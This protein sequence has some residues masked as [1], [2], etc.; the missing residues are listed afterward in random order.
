MSADRKERKLFVLNEFRGLDT[1]NKQLKVDK[2]RASF[3]YNFYSNSKTLKTR[4]A[5]VMKQD[6]PFF[7]ESGD[8]VIGWYY[9]NDLTIFITK[10]HFYIMNGE[11]IFHENNAPLVES[12]SVLIKSPNLPSSLNFEG[13]TP[14][15]HE[16]KDCLFIFGLPLNNSVGG[17][18]VLSTLLDENGDVYKYVLY[19]L[20]DKPVNPFEYTNDYYQPFEDLPTP[21]VPTL[22]IGNNVLDDVN[23][24][25]KKS[26]YRLFASSSDTVE[27]ETVYL[28][29]T[30]YVKD[31]HTNF[32]VDIDFYKNRFDS[33]VFPIFLGIESENFFPETDVETDYGL[34]LN[35]TPIDIVDTFYPAKEFEYEGTPGS[36]TKII[37]ELVG[38]DKNKFFNLRVKDT[39]GM[40]VFE[41]LLDYITLNPNTFGVGM[42]ENYTFE[43]T[44]PLEYYS[45]Y[46]DATSYEITDR[47]KEPSSI[48]VFVQFRKFEEQTSLM[49]T[50]SVEST[51]KVEEPYPFSSDWPSYPVTDDGDVDRFFTFEGE[52]DVQNLGDNDPEDTTPLY[53]PNYTETTFKNLCRAFLATKSSELTVEERVKV[54]GR[55]YD[56]HTV[57]QDGSVSIGISDAWFWPT[58]YEWDM[59]IVWNDPD[60]ITDIPDETEYPYFEPGER[61]VLEYESVISTTGIFPD[62]SV[63]TVLYNSIRNTLALLISEIVPKTYGNSGIGYFKFKV[64]TYWKTGDTT[65]YKGIPIVIQFTYQLESA[66]E[67]QTRQSFSYFCNIVNESAY[68]ID[69]LYTFELDSD[70]GYFKFT[71]RDYFF[72]YRNEPAIDIEVTFADNPDYDLVAN[73]KFGI[74]FGSENRLFLAGHEDHPNIDRYNVSNDLLGNNDIS[75]S[76]E[77]TYFPSKNYRVVGGKG[78]INGYVIATDS[79]MY[80]TKEKYPN[81]SV[82]FVRTRKMDDNGLVGYNEF[83]TS[84]KVTPLNHN[85]LVRF[86]N[87]IVILSQNGLIALE[88]SSNV[89]TDE[90]LEKSRDA[91]VYTE[92]KSA[93]NSV[94]KS[95]P[96]IVEDNTYMYI[97]IGKTV[98]VADA[99]LVAS[100]PNGELNNVSYEIVRWELQKKFRAGDFAGGELV[101]L[102]DSGEIFYEFDDENDK[103]DVITRHEDAIACNVFAESSHN[104][105]QL[106]SSFD[107]IYTNPEKTG[108]ILYSGYKLQASVTLEDYHLSPAGVGHID[109]SLAFRNVVDGDTLYFYDDVA[110]TFYPFVIDG[111][112]NS[113]RTEFTY[114]ESISGDQSVIYKNIAQTQLYISLIFDLPNS[115]IIGCRLSPYAHE[116]IVHITQEDE[117]AVEDYENR[118]LAAFDDNEDYF[119]EEAGM[120][121]IILNRE[122]EILYKWV[123]AILDFGNNYMEKTMFK[124]NIYANSINNGN[125]MKIGY[126]TMRGL[127]RTTDEEI[128]IVSANVFNFDFVDFTIFSFR[129]FSEFGTSFPCKENNFLYIQFVV[130]GEGQIELN[131]IEILYKLN[132]TLKT[133]G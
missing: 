32:T 121:D 92:L 83:K 94:N 21:Y 49:D 115:T 24:L 61:P 13:R 133:I 90:R 16:E 46:R 100:N 74:T 9:Y 72:D 30:H 67:Y 98:F 111:L 119:F 59:D 18:F 123:S 54:S 64:Q 130:W 88:L 110:E 25:C 126:K 7:L 22:M 77:L 26:K 75:Q 41:Y 5:F 66:T 3:G 36:V 73:N 116:D 53:K 37:S 131:A 108:I 99:R 6:I 14:I 42:T 51:S 125:I 55:L 58:D 33:N 31:K 109:N 128:V 89:L 79:Q 44:L 60:T 20:S 113:E 82:L 35:T 132:R 8:F 114:D 23:L 56:T 87:D 86:N 4:P 103:D 122:E 29:P 106:S 76:Y 38:L 91:F 80:V 50:E 102:D 28:L 43:F 95:E 52:V 62:F 118:V 85:C 96:F 11:T 1:Q 97:F 120:Q 69:N 47:I 104:Y 71:L 40:S 27:G 48:S 124:A 19:E 127:K 81:D 63:E 17:I 105:F 101:L 70:E 93:I 78:A 129:S 34:T 39:H 2:N 12:E 107:F 10:N 112:E 68:S 15:F 117:E 45:I 65:Y 57:Y 84:V